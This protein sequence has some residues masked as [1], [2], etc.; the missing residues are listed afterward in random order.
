M[1]GVTGSTDA[2]VGEFD[3]SPAVSAASPREVGFPR[4]FGPTPEE[5]EN[6]M[7][8]VATRSFTL[9]LL[10]A[11]ACVAVL[12]AASPARAAVVS[13]WTMLSGPA[14]SPPNASPG[15]G[16][17]QVDIDPV[18]HTM[19]VRA[20]FSDLIGTTT[21]CHIHGPTASPGVST[22]GVMT[23][24]PSFPGFPAGV[25]AGVYDA[26]FDMTQPSSYNA[27]F[28]N[29]AINLGSTA[30]A[31]ASLFAAIAEGKAYFNVHTTA[32]GGG[33][34]R[35]FFQLLDPT[36]AAPTSWGR[37]KQLYR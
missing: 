22:A 21:I 5:E 17:A 36:P 6:T 24:T 29:N 13:Y 1:Q 19:R 27:S 25:T 32:F 8:P 18:A 15:I 28:L 16:T 11:V 26:T 30:T 7:R 3:R 33:E 31:E 23:P 12:G 4:G 14:E 20:Q 34:I 35:G 2:P 10:L 37:I 9:R